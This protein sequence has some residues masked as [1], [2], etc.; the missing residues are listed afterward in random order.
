MKFSIILTTSMLAVSVLSGCRDNCQCRDLEDC[1]D[2]VC[3]L[4]PNSYYLNNQGI[5]GN[6]LY[7]G[8]VYGSACVDTLVLNLDL[9]DP[10]PTRKASLYAVVP[11][12]GAINVAAD[13]TSKISDT[14]YTFGS[15]SPICYKSNLVYWYASYIHCKMFTDSIQM[16]IKFRQSDDPPNAGYIDSCRLTLYK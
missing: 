15:V 12:H 10:N 3:V 13:F 7:H 5:V 4:K 11:P 16:Q 9:E 2:E 8:V 14:E 6:D 1:I